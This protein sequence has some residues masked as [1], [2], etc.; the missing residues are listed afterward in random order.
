ML[1]RVAT[2][3]QNRVSATA[4]TK[5]CFTFTAM[6][7]ICTRHHRSLIHT[8]LDIMPA[9]F[10]RSCSNCAKSKRRCNLGRPRCFRCQVRSLECN[11]QPQQT[12]VQSS[13]S[14]AVQAAQDLPQYAVFDAMTPIA[15]SQEN[16]P[17]INLDMSLATFPDY[18]LDWADVMGNIDNYMVPDDL[19][20]AYSPSTSV[21]ACD[22]YQERVVYLVKRLK[23][24]LNIFVAQG[25]TAFIHCKLFSEYTPTAIE[26]ALGIC[27]LYGHKN[28]DNEYLIFRSLAQRVMSLV[29]LFDP[30]RL[31][32]LD[33][34]ASV[35]ALIFYQII[36]VFDGDI[37]QRADAERTDGVLWEWTQRLKVYLPQEGISPATN[38]ADPRNYAWRTWILA[39]SIRRTI[40][41][42]LLLQ[43]LY[44]YLKHGWNKVH[45][46]IKDVSFYGQRALWD[47]RSAHSWKT[48]L[49][50]YSPLLLHLSTWDADMQNAKP[51][52]MD[53]LG[54]LMMTVTKGVDDTCDWLGKDYMDMF[55]LK[56]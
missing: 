13:S 34:L 14:T 21:V 26:D 2:A 12:V 1:S 56:R 47:A 51:S 36:R 10:R 23:S 35:Q 6:V 28:K 53:D 54:V 25:S 7:L 39:E 22:M 40:L 29:Q 52:D 45:F 24:Y 38:D 49:G 46:E 27:A 3:F 9:P 44:S 55:D 48:T 5:E 31:S 15:S 32:V 41:V 18:D 33:Q 37:R 16:L 50:E 42:S 17:A 43:G 30:Q 19:R 11:Y 8:R 20:P 4:G